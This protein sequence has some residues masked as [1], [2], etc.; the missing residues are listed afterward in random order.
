MNQKKPHSLNDRCLVELHLG[1]L[2]LTAEQL[3]E[4]LQLA[5]NLKLLRH[6]QL[7]SAL[8]RLHA[9]KWRGGGSVPTYKLMNLD[10]D[11]SHVVSYTLK[12]D[13]FKL[14]VIFLT[15]GSTLAVP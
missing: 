5:P 6:Y 1:T 15:L 4:I 11:F 2:S 7:V 12:M 9:D 13:V 10:A 3:V 8:Y 14:C